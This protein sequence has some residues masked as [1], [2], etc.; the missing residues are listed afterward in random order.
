[1]N[2]KQGKRPNCRGAPTRQGGRVAFKLNRRQY[3]PSSPTTLRRG[4]AGPLTT[5]KAA[6]AA[7]VFPLPAKGGQG[8]NGEEWDVGVRL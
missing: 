6:R 3:L 8:E 7:T 2:R 1:M 5:P 4:L